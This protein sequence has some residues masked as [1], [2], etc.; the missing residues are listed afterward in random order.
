MQFKIWLG[1]PEM[2][3][4]WQDMSARYE[5]KELNKNELKEFK[6]LVKYIQLVKN[7]PRHTGLNTHEISSLSKRYGLKVWQSYL[8]NNT[9]GAGRLYWVY[10]PAKGDI[11]IIGMEPHPDDTRKAAYEKILSIAIISPHM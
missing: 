8:E 2:Q 5:R 4:Y 7:N 11:T 3:E 1:V 6:R 9:P 10:G